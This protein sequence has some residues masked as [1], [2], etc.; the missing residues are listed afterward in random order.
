M[1]F[2]GKMIIEKK[3]GEYHVD[4]VKSI[5]FVGYATAACI[6]NVRFHRLEAAVAYALACA[7]SF[8]HL[9]KDTTDFCREYGMKQEQVDNLLSIPYEEF[10]KLFEYAEDL[11]D[12]ARHGQICTNF[13]SRRKYLPIKA[14]RKYIKEGEADKFKY[15]MS[16]DSP[17]A[18][19]RR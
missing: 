2:F 10:T 6:S 19:Y 16:N 7:G 11:E 14:L 12:I 5:H 15:L 18:K 8:V 1:K 17:L 3:F 4:D 9:N 13:R